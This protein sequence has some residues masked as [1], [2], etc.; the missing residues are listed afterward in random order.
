MICF[1]ITCSHISP[2]ATFHD[3][4]LTEWFLDHGANPNQRCDRY[5]DCTP[6]S[7]AFRKADFSIVKLLLERG[8]S[9]QQGQVLH[10]AAMRELDDRLDV[11]DYLLRK[12][13]SVN[14]IM[15]QNCGD[16]YYFD[17]Y[18]G[19]GTP[20]HYAA[21]R[22]LPDSVKL[23]IENG[24]SPRIKDPGGRVALEWAEANGQSL[25][26]EFLCPL[27]IDRVLET[28]SQHTAETGRHFNTVPMEKFLRKVVINW[29]SDL[30][31]WLIV[32][33]N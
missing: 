33:R 9:L 4:D 24:A 2:S 21:A 22:G 16:E 13:L 3:R 31:H 7:V 15:Y 10:Y 12:G 1:V 17:M 32:M 11:L 26:A 28:A 29:S 5:R 6:L 23:L 14:D 8:A 25:V 20:L 18:S 19:I 27:S 30:C